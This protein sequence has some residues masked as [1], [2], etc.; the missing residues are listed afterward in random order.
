[1]S[2]FLFTYVSRFYGHPVQFGICF[3]LSVIIVQYCGYYFY[4]AGY[5]YDNFSSVIVHFITRSCVLRS[6]LLCV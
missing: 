3:L 1:M 2:V 5:C 6:P 4:T